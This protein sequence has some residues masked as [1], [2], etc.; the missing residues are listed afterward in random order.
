MPTPKSKLS[1]LILSLPS[2]LS[3]AQVVDQV[4][5]NGMKTS[6]ANVSRVRALYG[7]K[8]DKTAPA[9]PEAPATSKTTLNGSDFIRA[10]PAS[11]SPAEVVAKAK[12][13]GI[14]FSP[15]LVYMV[16]RAKTAKKGAAKKTSTAPTRSPPAKA[17]V[18]SKS[19]F[20][21]AHP[22]STPKEIVEKAKG[23]AKPRATSR[24]GVAVRRRPLTTTFSA[25]ELLRAVAAELGLGRAVEILAG[26]RAKVRAV[27]GG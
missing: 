24:I 19:D 2:T 9:T 14:E 10:Q 25:E 16:R 1:K 3:G 12:T 21:R 18:K 26:E 7:A 23:A 15:S 20:V 22:S 8:G 13:E 27:M 11:M 5:A 17:A 6:R 4:K